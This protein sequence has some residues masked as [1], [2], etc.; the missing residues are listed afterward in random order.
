MP[1][2]YHRPPTVKRRKAR[3][4]GSA[5][6]DED[7]IGPAAAAG[8]EALPDDFSDEEWDEGEKVEDSVQP[9]AVVETTAQKATRE[10]TRHIQR[11]YSYVRSE[12]TRIAVLAVVLLA[13][14]LVVAI[15][16]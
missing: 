8:A 11:D 7:T 14:L 10:A 13:A 3:R 4:P 2:R 12:L 9:V 16:R 5:G 1:R 15:L 6:T